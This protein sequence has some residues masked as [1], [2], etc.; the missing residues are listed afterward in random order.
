MRILVVE[1][2]QKVANALKEGL[3]GEHF[4]NPFWLRSVAAHPK[5]RYPGRDWV[6]WQY[7]GSGLSHG[8]DGKID[9]NVFRGSEQDWWAWV[10]GATA[11]AS[12]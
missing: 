7:S 6:F 1:D 4:D 2:E 11:V 9:L 10:S 8:V 3:E 5:K 12:R